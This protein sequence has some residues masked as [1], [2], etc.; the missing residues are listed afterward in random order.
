MAK[1]NKGSTQNSNTIPI[2]RPKLPNIA[3]AIYSPKVPDNNIPPTISVTYLEAKGNYGIEKLACVHK[4]QRGTRD[5]IKEFDDFLDKARKYKNIEELLSAHKPKIKMKNSDITSVKKMMAL[6]KKYNIDTSDMIHIHCKG[7][8][9]G[10]F[11]I[12]GFRQSNNLEI[13]W[14]DPEH[15]VHC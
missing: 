7:G 9:N 14:L 4:K 12:H 3:Q 6:Q 10:P 11:V 8:G 15:E 5:V 2:D 13:V 1:S